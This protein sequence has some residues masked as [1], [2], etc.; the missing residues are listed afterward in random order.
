LAANNSAANQ[1]IVTPANASLITV[2]P[3]IFAGS[4]GPGNFTVNNSANSTNSSTIGAKGLNVT[5]NTS[6]GQNISSKVGVVAN[7]THIHNATVANAT[8]LA[9]NN[10]IT[11]KNVTSVSTSTTATA[12]H[13]CAAGFL[14]N[15]TVGKCVPFNFCA[16]NTPGYIFVPH[17]N[18][19]E[20]TYLL[21]GPN[22]YYSIK[23]KTCLARSLLCTPG[24]FYNRT[25]HTCSIISTNCP[26]GHYF[27]HVMQMCVAKVPCPKGS[28]LNQTTQ[29]CQKK[30]H[31][32]GKSQYFDYATGHCVT[33]KFITSPYENNLIYNGFFKSYVNSYNKAENVTH[34]PINCP[35]SKP[36]YQKSSQTCISCPTATPYFDLTTDKCVS[37]SYSQYYDPY[38]HKCVSQY[39]SPYYPS[40]ISR[41]N[42]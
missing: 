28:F 38:A 27:N 20:P 3:V 11:T 42:L 32:C 12:K 39:N 24:Q 13:A 4:A 30:G 19:C 36:Y 18:K 21:C 41:I 22:Q 5:T 34:P 14:Y 9:K 29:L 16:T 26:T 10:T 17:L 40:T 2:Y 7:L 25:N 31:K 23:H 8:S 6:A 15:S 35:T 1:T 33:T 37:C